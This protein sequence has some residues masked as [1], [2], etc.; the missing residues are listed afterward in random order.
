MDSEIARDAAFRA[1]EGKQ[2]PQVPRWRATAVATWRPDEK[3]AFTVAGRYSD[4]VYATI[5]NTDPVTHTYQGFDDYLVFDV[6]AAL[7]L[8][9][10]WS[11]AVGIE[12][13]GGEDYYIFHPFPQRTATAELKYRF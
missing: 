2:A 1:A 11:A 5:D 7:A 8:N 12:N 6:R 9:T 4:R 3:W 10:H 13:I